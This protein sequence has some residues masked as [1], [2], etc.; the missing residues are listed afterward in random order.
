MAALVVI[1][2]FLGMI[3]ETSAIVITTVPIFV[4]VLRGMG[5]DLVYFG[6]VLALLMSIGT[7]TPPVGTVLFVIAKITKIPIERLT[8]VMLPW[9]GV[10]LTVVLLLIIFPQII[11]F[12]PRIMAR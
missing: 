3:M 8:K 5:V 2:L 12:I 6:I 10:L 9:Y 7:I 1:Y 4:P 11:L